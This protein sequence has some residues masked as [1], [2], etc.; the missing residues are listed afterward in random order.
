MVNH[1][2]TNSPD[3]PATRKAPVHALYVA[4]LVVGL[5]SVHS[6]AAAAEN[7][8][9]GPYGVGAQTLASG[10]L[11]PQGATVQ[12]GYLAY[13]SASKFVDDNGHSAIPGFEVNVAVEA[14][15]TRHTW[16]FTYGGFT[17]GSALIQEAAH[18]DVE[19]AG[20]SDSAR[21]PVFVNIQPLAIG[22]HMGDWHVLTAT[23]LLFPLG[24][25]DRNAL[26]NSAN[27]YFTFTQEL[28]VTWIPTAKWMLDL[29]SNISI[30]RRNPK[31]D[32]RSGDLVDFT[33]G[34]NYRPF[35][36]DPRWQVGVSGIYHYQYQDD[37]VKGKEVPG[38]FRLRK[39]NAGPQLGFWLTPAAAVVLKWHK[40]W[41]V[42][43]GPQGDV[44][45]LQ[46][47]FPI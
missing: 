1:A 19:A 36:S 22:R 18:V 28:S 27:N 14:T 46:A 30:N 43:N 29:S 33:W 26:A 23:H 32:Y 8:G 38:G 15:M 25:Y 34:A 39:F 47:A 3:K 17:F 2:S 37:E 35:E 11:A 12:Y 9:F 13:Y 16:D 44:F 20:T 42:R 4:L 31:T 21:G 6:I 24:S 41:E 10:I 7:G 45:W 5:S 40:E